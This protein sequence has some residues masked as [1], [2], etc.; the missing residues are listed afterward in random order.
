MYDDADTAQ[1]NSLPETQVHRDVD[2]AIKEASEDINAHIVLPSTIWGLASHPLVE[3]GLSNFRS[4]Q[5]GTMSPCPRASISY[6]CQVPALV[7]ASIHRGQAGVVGS[8]V[9]H[10][11]NV[12]VEEVAQ[13][14]ILILEAAL[15]GKLVS[16]KSG[17]YFFGESGEHVVGD[18]SKKIGETLA[19]KGI[20]KPEP[21]AFTPQDI[22]KYFGG[23]YYLGSTSRAKA[24]RARQLGW[25]PTKSTPDFLNSISAEVELLLKEDPKSW[26][27]GGKL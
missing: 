27:F 26:N 13:I 11:P 18:I 19:A 12:H 17:S 9:N 2:L 10:W 25:N 8:G 24:S 3:S 16:G 1:V 14:Y 15:A 4:I 21:T 6:I 23:S 5:V 20:G 7:R 22:A